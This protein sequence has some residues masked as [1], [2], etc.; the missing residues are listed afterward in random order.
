MKNCLNRQKKKK[1]NK[2]Q[3]GDP[4]LQVVR[5]VF[6]DHAE[7][8]KYI[9]YTNFDVY[10]I[11]VTVKLKLKNCYVEES[12][13]QHQNFILKPK[14][15]HHFTIQQLQGTNGYEAF[16]LQEHKRRIRV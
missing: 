16:I 3:N 7:R 10:T 14:E 13:S 5:D 1:Q 2:T 11:E 4:P 15:S 6:E 8:K 12:F 9:I